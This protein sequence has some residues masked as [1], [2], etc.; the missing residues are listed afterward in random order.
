[1][2]GGQNCPT[3]ARESLEAV[4]FSEKSLAPGEPI[5]TGVAGEAF[6]CQVRLSSIAI[7]V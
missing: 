1:V 3:K 7:R 5:F 6:W 4:A 2:R